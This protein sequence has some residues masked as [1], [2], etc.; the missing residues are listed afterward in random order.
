MS[1]YVDSTGVPVE[2]GDDP[3]AGMTLDGPVGS[4][5]R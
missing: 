4:H 5:G 2:E 1:R 3:Y